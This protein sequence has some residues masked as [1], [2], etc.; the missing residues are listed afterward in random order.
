VI[1]IAR[2]AEPLPLIEKF[3]DGDKTIIAGS[4]WK[5]DELVLK[6]AFTI[7]GDSA[8]KLIIAPHEVNE[9]HLNELKTIFPNSILYSQLTTYDSRLT[10][11]VSRFLIIDNIGMLSRL[12]KYGY[13]AYVGGG[14]NKT[15]I[16]NVLEAAVYDKIVLFGPNYE[17]YSEAIGLV[18]AGGALPYYDTRKDG[19][20]LAGL[21]AALVL[22]KKD[23]AIRSKAAGDY[24]RSQE[25]ATD[26]ILHYIQ[27]KR[28]LTS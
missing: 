7:L 19:Q 13:L 26:K 15:G 14:F 2:K 8:P 24:V 9:K 1:G 10:T 21:I 27:E 22:D 20:M 28:L 25:G 12:Y 11:H 23:H 6:N 18:D 5:E 16:H 3:I 4:T 17:K